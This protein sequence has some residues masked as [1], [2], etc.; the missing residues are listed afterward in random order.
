[1]EH[2]TEAAYLIKNGDAHEA[3]EWRTSPS[4]SPASN[5]VRVKVE[6]FGL[7]FADVLA[8]QGLYRE[9]PPLPC[10]L[11]YDL[12]GRV[13]SVGEN[14]ESKWI[15]KRVI[16][17]TRFGAYATYVNTPEVA[18]VE[19]P[20]D[21]PD[22]A[23]C[24]LGTQYATAYYSARYL[25]NTRKGERVLVHA[26]MGGVGTALIQLLKDAGCEIYGTVGSE[27]KKT[28]LEALGVKAFNY[29]DKD[30]YDQIERALNGQKL[31]VS[32]NSIAGT[33]F[34]KDMKL[35]GANGRF[36][37]HGFAERSGKKTGKLATYQLLWNMGIVIPIMMLAF[38][39]S[40]LGVNMLKVGDYK[41]QI[42]QECMQELVKLWQEGRIQPV[43]G[44]VYNKS[45]LTDAHSDLEH[46]KVIGKA[47]IRF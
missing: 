8:R 33:T 19:I 30:V 25:Q 31:D 40:I 1:M 20:E 46:R 2:V 7:N 41:P 9:A 21:M 39:K 42:I 45:Q 17:L 29:K 47:I 27:A 12:V 36:I 11:G 16:S 5:E 22:Y 14:V 37:L 3:F 24:A 4:V 28:Q 18:I 15:G 23:A 13:E 38:S 35:L 34:K 26:A 6:A 10:V 43:N 44:G 32:F